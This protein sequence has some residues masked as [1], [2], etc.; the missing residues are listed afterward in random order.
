MVNKKELYEKFVR[1]QRMMGRLRFRAK[2][3]LGAVND[4]F[5][6]QGRVLAILKM[7][8]EV[9]A[10]DLAYMLDL[11][12]SSLN[13]LL[14]KLE[15]GGYITRAPA[16][17][18]K[19]VVMIRLTEKGRNFEPKGQGLEDIFDALSEG[20]REN[21]NKYLDRMIEELKKRMAE[22]GDDFDV[23]AAM[24]RFRRGAER[25]GERFD[26][27]LMG[28]WRSQRGMGGSGQSECGCGAPDCSD[29]QSCDCG[30]PGCGCGDDP[31]DKGGGK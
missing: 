30:D 17:A 21:L 26:D 5:R 4:T 11:R 22:E 7:K 9:S 20:E 15:N 27:G 16:E 23:M 13:E 2:V 19:R 3:D 25:F 18:D 14:N 1:M 6:G 24:R 28:F 31:D 10:G 29:D 8:P 12:P